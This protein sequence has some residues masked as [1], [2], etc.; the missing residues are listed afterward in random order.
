[1]PKKY[2]VS[3]IVRLIPSSVISIACMNSELGILFALTT[4]ARHARNSRC[5]ASLGSLR[6]SLSDRVSR[7]S[8]SVRN[9]TGSGEG[10]SDADGSRFGFGGAIIGTSVGIGGGGRSGFGG[11]GGWGG[12]ARKDGFRLGVDERDDIR[13]GVDGRDGVRAGVL[14]CDGMPTGGAGR[15]GGDGRVAAR[16]AGDLAGGVGAR[17][18]MLVRE[19]TERV[20]GMPGGVM[21]ASGSTGE[22]AGGATSPAGNASTG[23]AVDTTIRGISVISSRDRVPGS[24][25]DPVD[26]EDSD[27]G[28]EGDLYAEGGEVGETTGVMTLFSGSAVCF[29]PRRDATR[30]G[31]SAGT[32]LAELM[33]CFSGWLGR[34]MK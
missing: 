30:I 8:L 29:S 2:Q 3:V 16:R 26:L 22:G 28:D 27:D 18:A 32:L 33:V 24:T 10:G 19:D 12:V 34:C 17:D 14:G 7:P 1:M 4:S 25:V 31:A 23:D 13:T 20:S 6:G 5:R 11:R 9:R 21:G 15:E